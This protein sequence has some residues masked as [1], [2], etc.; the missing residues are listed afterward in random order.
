MP[1]GAA[2]RAK[3]AGAPK[4]F[5]IAAIPNVVPNKPSREVW[6]R[7]SSPAASASD[8]DSAEITR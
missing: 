5:S 6:A 3:A 8:I 2:N 7:A 4:A 1:S